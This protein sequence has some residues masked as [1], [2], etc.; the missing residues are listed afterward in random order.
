MDHRLEKFL[1]LSVALTG[2]GRLA[3]LGTGVGAEYLQALDR[4]VPVRI[5]NDFLQRAESL[6]AKGDHNT[7]VV[8]AILDDRV[9]GPVARNVIVMWYCGTWSVLPDDWRAEHGASEA[10]VPHVISAAAYL[11]GLQWTTIGAHPPGGLPGGFGSW[12]S[13]PPGAKS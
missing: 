8:H 1:E 6:S 5:V 7:T 3:L 13:P 2:F 9:L 4:I 12:A 11:T 10:D